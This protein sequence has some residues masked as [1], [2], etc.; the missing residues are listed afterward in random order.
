LAA[1]H[2]TLLQ[3]GVLPSCDSPIS[4]AA[5]NSRTSIFR[6][7][8]AIHKVALESPRQPYGSPFFLP[9]IDVRAL[10]FKSQL[11][12]NLMKLSKLTK[13]AGGWRSK[14]AQGFDLGI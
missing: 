6:R 10:Q 3:K 9:K 1:R 2:P 14:K 7:K 4:S 11:F 13:K 8:K 12:P 5:V